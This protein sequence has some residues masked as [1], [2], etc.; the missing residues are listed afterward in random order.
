MK[1]KMARP[2]VSQSWKRIGCMG[3]GQKKHPKQPALVSSEEQLCSLGHWGE[4]P[5]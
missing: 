3:M 1:K 4:I 2:T 5:F